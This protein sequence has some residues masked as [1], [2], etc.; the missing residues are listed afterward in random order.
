MTSDILSRVITMPHDRVP[1]GSTGL[2]LQVRAGLTAKGSSLN[3]WC[4]RQGVQRSYAHRALTGETNGPAALALR[5][6]LV[7]ESQQVAA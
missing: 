1:A 7:S 5:E 6:R 4:Q 3:A 2:L